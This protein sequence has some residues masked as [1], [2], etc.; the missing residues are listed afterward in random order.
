M[1]GGILYDALTLDEVR[2][3][4][5]PCGAHWWVNP[6]ALKADRKSITPAKAGRR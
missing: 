1:K 5:A 4:T 3:A 6:D 2:P